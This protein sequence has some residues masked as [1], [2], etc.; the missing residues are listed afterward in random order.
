MI[1]VAAMG[2][3]THAA[4][5]NIRW[6]ILLFAGIGVVVGGQLG[7]AVAPKLRQAIVIRMLAAGMGVTGLWL[8]VRGAGWV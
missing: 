8:I 7:A 5:G 4:F 3:V 2:T 1:P 6:L